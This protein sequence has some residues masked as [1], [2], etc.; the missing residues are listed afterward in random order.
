M[1]GRHHN[2]TSL[3]AAA[4]W[5]VL[6]SSLLWLSGAERAAG[7]ATPWELSPARVRICIAWQAG[8]EW[9]PA[10]RT[11]A[12]TFTAARIEQ[13]VG[14]PWS[15][16]VVEC[17]A[18]VR[19]R[20]LRTLAGEVPTA[21]AWSEWNSALS[22]VESIDKLILAQV[23]ATGRQA[24][25]AVR[26]LDFAARQVGPR[27]ERTTADPRQAGAALFRAIV[28]AH[29]P[30][31][32]VVH[33][34]RQRATLSIR[35]GGLICRDPDL[36]WVRP[37]R[38]FQVVQRVQDRLGTL[39][40][41]DRVPWTF[42]TIDEVDGP[43]ARCRVV[44]GIRA[45]V[46]APRGRL[47]H[48]ALGVPAVEGSTRLRLVSRSGG[49]PLVGYTLSAEAEGN[50]SAQSLGTTDDHGE[51]LVPPGSGPVRVLVAW[52]GSAALARLPLAP[53]L[54]PQLTAALPDDEARFAAEGLVRGI[55][56]QFA[57]HLARRRLLLMRIERALGQ[58]RSAE[59]QRAFD[60]LL[61]AESRLS[62]A[63]AVR[64]LEQQTLAADPATEARID[65]RLAETRAV[66]EAYAFGPQ[67]EELSRRIREAA[68]ATAP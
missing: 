26:E 65:R 57:D 40:R 23:T 15:A 58:G 62:L 31:G 19:P 44:S 22:A 21:E 48:L 14:G 59:A 42:L 8:P 16:A 7:Q 3:T 28:A 33:V 35:G 6:L 11:D 47:E 66:I 18:D 68:A 10:S 27:I 54:E 13:V 12:I 20:L 9:G 1:T 53:G 51:L 29:A 67:R 30:L 61:E 4:G 52:H 32:R 45:A 34:E 41:A 38:A 63:E 5:A 2:A 36:A 64:E 39:R 25:V 55:E 60:E 56:T 49:Q 24:T 46:A 37:G 43:L 50:A 17:P